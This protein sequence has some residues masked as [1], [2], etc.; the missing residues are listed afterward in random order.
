VGSGGAEVLLLTDK[1]S[2]VPVIG[3]MS[4]QTAL[5]Q[6]TNGQFLE[7]RYTHD[8]AFMNGEILLTT[9]D[10]T[11]LPSGIPVAKIV[12]DNRGTYAVPLYH[13]KDIDFVQ[14]LY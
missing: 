13:P 6:G 9:G 11:F 10:D 2:R 8:R 1:A 3:E 14:V 5:L 7:M 4:H 12:I